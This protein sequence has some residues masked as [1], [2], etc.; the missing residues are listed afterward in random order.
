MRFPLAPEAVVEGR[1][2]FNGQ[3]VPGVYVVCEQDPNRPGHIGPAPTAADGSYRFD[4]LAAGEVS[5]WVWRGGPEE[6]VA[7]LSMPLELKVGEHVTGHDLV[8]SVGAVL[9][10][11]VTEAV[12]GKPVAGAS[13]WVDLEK[14]APPT[15]TGAAH[16]VAEPLR[17]GTVQ[18]DATG[19]YQLRVPP[20]RYKV[21]AAAP[22]SAIVPRT[23]PVEVTDGDRKSG[24][25][26]ALTP[27]PQIH[28]RVLLP[29]G[30]PAVGATVFTN[31]RTYE[32]GG[33]ETNEFAATTAADGS[34]AIGIEQSGNPDFAPGER[35]TA[36]MAL[37]PA[38]GL[39]GWVKIT[40][41]EQ[42]MEIHLARG[43]YVT[44]KVVDMT[45]R[46]VAGLQFQLNWSEPGQRRP[47]QYLFG[48]TNALGQ[49]RFGPLPAETLELNLSEPENES[50]TDESWQYDNGLRMK[51]RAGQTEELPLMHL[52]RQGRSAALRVVDAQG[53][54]V[55]GALVMAK[56]MTRDQVFY[57]DGRG[58]LVIT[59]LPVHGEVWI[60]VKHPGQ[61]LYDVRLVDPDQPGVTRFV[62]RPLGSLSGQLVDEQGRPVT[63]RQVLAQPDQQRIG[64]GG[65]EIWALVHC[66]QVAATASDRG[67]RPE[68]EP[69]ATPDGHG[70]WKL[71]DL[72]SGISYSL[73]AMREDGWMPLRPDSRVFLVRPGETTDVG[74]V[75]LNPPPTHPRPASSH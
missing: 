43:A 62:V 72:P 33:G 47:L 26:F 60:G 57:A 20:G 35:Q 14:A 32:F 71:D 38:A 11:K 28:G 50:I 46:P 13:V 7:P 37:L 48:T 19:T 29:D 40:D 73:L 12:T 18:T 34:F 25:D 22:D 36:I 6:T 64:W 61:P 41:L 58:S 75:V 17:A 39:A 16:P 59:G 3:G 68:G 66:L 23:R 55:A 70:R 49:Y 21:T 56:V 27:P 8:F 24:L 52:N 65:I 15:E 44:G 2:M 31:N 54:P 51:L 74:Q 4:R 30:K 1:V 5:L 42:P 63:D 9:S 10:G 45:G 69:G 67:P 53:K